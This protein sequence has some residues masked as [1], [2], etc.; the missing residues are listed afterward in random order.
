MPVVILVRHGRTTANT[1]GILA[2]WSP[3]VFLD[4]DGEKQAVRTAERLSAVALDAIVSSPLDR[5][6]QTADAIALKQN[7]V[8]RHVDDRLGEC[9]YGDWTNKTLTELADEPLWRTVQAH[10]SAVTFPGG[11]SMAA[12]QHRAVSAVREWNETLGAD[13]VYAVVSHG[14]VIKAI[15]AD[16]LGMHLDA[17]QRIQADPCSISVVRYTELRPFVVVMNDSNMDLGSLKANR[18]GS[19]AAVGGGAG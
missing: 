18:E 13:A 10:P 2:G 11:E 19:D 12:M 3:G 7:D 1:A 17:F 15:L 5:T 6:M 8:A 16:A 9:Q 14:D 4:E